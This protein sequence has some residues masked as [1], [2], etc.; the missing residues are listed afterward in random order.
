MLFLFTFRYRITGSQILTYRQPFTGKLLKF[1][2]SADVVGA[3]VAVCTADGVSTDVVGTS[4]EPCRADGTTTDVAG[5][6]VKSCR[7]DGTKYT[8]IYSECA[9]PPG[10]K[11]GSAHSPAGEG[12]GESQFRRLDKKLSILPTLWLMG[13]PLML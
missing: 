8:Y 7:A 1:C 12:L 5:A 4:V 6:P 11:G 10:T 3:S 9:P 13:Y 2:T